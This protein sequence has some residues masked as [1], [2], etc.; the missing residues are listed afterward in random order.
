VKMIRVGLRCNLNGQMI[1]TTCKSQQRPRNTYRYDGVIEGWREFNAFVRDDSTLHFLEQE[2]Q[3]G[4]KVRCKLLFSFPGE[5][6]V[7]S[8]E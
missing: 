8:R 3:I 7:T 1:S 4:V 6:F 2:R 5:P